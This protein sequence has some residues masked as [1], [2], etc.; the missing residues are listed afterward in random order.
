VKIAAEVMPTHLRPGGAN[1][2]GDLY[3]LLSIGLHDL[4]DEQCCDIVDAMDKSLKFIYT[5]LKIHA[6]DAR[7][8]EQA[9]KSI[10]ETVTKLKQRNSK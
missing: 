6:E 4:T 1:P 5:Q 8:Y 10:H 2:F 3:E 9:V 7:A